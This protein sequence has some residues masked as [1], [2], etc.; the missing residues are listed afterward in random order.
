MNLKKVTP[1]EIVSDK[2]YL[3]KTKDDEWLVGYFIDF[4]GMPKLM[5]EHYRVDIS[6]LT[7]IYEI[8]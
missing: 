2:Y 1:N 4:E 7:E 8:P 6:E 3:C 5:W